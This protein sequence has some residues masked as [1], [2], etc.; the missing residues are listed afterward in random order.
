MY[1]EHKTTTA[2]A[3]VNIIFDILIHKIDIRDARRIDTCCALSQSCPIFAN[4]R[5]TPHL[6]AHIGAGH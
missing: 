5:L 3:G 4:V 6:C 1:R 2:Q